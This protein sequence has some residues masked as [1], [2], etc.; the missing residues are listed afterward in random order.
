MKI[1]ICG[2]TKLEDAQLCV[3]HGVD[4]IGFI[5]YPKSKRYISPDDARIIANGL[6]IFTHKIGVFVNEDVKEVNRI[7]KYVGLSAVQLHGNETVE[8]VSQIT[9]PV[10]KSFGVDESFDYSTLN[11]YL[12]CGILL[13]VKDLEQH[14]GTGN[15]FDW[16]L[17]PKDVRNKIIIAGG[18]S[19][20]N[21]ENIYEKINPYGVDLSSSVELSPGIKDS[22]KIIEV[23]KIVNKIKQKEYD[24]RTN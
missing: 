23:L 20:N 16:G 4:A 15:S 3:E 2:I 5:F 1:K 18:V 10:I 22:D 6:P 19:T 11:D 24:K 14:G 9:H 13:D 12:N 21:I 17:I 7:A 8:Y